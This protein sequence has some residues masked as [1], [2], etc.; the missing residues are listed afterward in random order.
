MN[1]QPVQHLWKL[2]SHRQAI[3]TCTFSAVGVLGCYVPPKY[4]HASY[5]TIAQPIQWLWKL[6]AHR[7]AIGMG[8][9]LA[10][11]V[12]GLLHIHM[13]IFT[14]CVMHMAVYGGVDIWLC[15]ST[16]V[17]TEVDLLDTIA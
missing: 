7:K 10:V 5:S 6:T 3:G 1:S 8:T 17:I 15:N 13:L 12:S 16:V 2:T 4:T 9:F 14:G 11:V